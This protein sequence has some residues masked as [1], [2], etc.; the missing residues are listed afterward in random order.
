MWKI[1]QTSSLFR[2]IFSTTKPEKFLPLEDIKNYVTPCSILTFNLGTKGV[3]QKISILGVERSTSAAF[4]IKYAT[5]KIACT[6]VC[7]EGN[8]LKQLTHLPFVPKLELSICK[9]NEFALIKT[10]V[11][12]GDKM[13]YRP[14]DKQ[15]LTILFTLSDQT[16]VSA[17]NY[18]SGIRSCFSHG[19][20]CPWNMLVNNG[21]ID[22][23]DWELAGEYPLGYDLFM[24][25]FQF[26]FLVNEMNRFD[27]MLDQNADVIQQY[28]N[29]F[30]IEEWIPYLQEFS[31]L[32]CKLE[33]EK[34]NSQLIEPYLKLKE[35]ATKM[36]IKQEHVI[37]S[38]S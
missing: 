5:S 36:N 6:N 38:F 14:I 26:E 25:I 32:R 7:N 4:Y 8:V 19:D 11:L 18:S 9:E 34:N 35:Y 23:F 33:L 20:F 10:T 1:W 3:E 27:C 16:V 13:K 29:H 15:M 12:V 30:E 22:L 17:R 2:R 21:K 28:F 24:Y 31:M 37:H